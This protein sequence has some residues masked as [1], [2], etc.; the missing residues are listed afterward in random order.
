MLNDQEQPHN[1]RVKENTVAT[2]KNVKVTP[3]DQPVESQ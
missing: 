1:S 3:P 2:S